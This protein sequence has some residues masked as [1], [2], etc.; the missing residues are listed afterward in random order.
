MRP[1]L[2][3]DL[4][5]MHIFLFLQDKDCQ[6]NN[7]Y[8]YMNNMSGTI[9]AAIVGYGNRRYASTSRRPRLEIAGVDDVTE[10]LLSFNLTVVT[11][12]AQLEKVDVAL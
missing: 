4:G 1:D 11:D 2:K 5:I 10:I 8:K 9:R 3:W 7:N 12:I 6:S